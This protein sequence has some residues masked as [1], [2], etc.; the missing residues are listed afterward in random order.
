M[1]NPEILATSTAGNSA[2]NVIQVRIHAEQAEAANQ[3]ANQAATDRPRGKG[4][5]SARAT[6]SPTVACAVITDQFAAYAFFRDHPA[7]KHA[8]ATA[9]NQYIRA[10]DNLDVR[11]GVRFIPGVRVDTERNA[12]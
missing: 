1:T 2:S 6:S 9:A 8:I 12:A 10:K 11:Q 5:H 7:V 4:D 3:A